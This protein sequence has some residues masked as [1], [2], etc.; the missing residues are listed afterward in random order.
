MRFS[1]SKVHDP[2]DAARRAGIK[3]EHVTAQNAGEHVIADA[4][5][6]TVLALRAME[7]IGADRSLHEDVAAPDGDSL[8]RGIADKCV[9]EP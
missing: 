1:V 5:V 4:A 9:I 6:K 8:G 2:V 3:H 7:R